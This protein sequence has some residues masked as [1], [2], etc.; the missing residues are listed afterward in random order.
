MALIDDDADDLAAAADYLT[1]YIEHNHI[2]LSYNMKLTNYLSPKKF[3]EEFYGGRFD[4]I[5]LDIFMDEMS[6]INVAQLIRMK[7]RDEAQAADRDAD[8]GFH[9]VD[10]VRRMSAL[11]A[12]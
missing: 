3:V 7:D 9:F 1:H 10:A 2:E 12:D 5:V 11:V 4:L 8:A 6:G